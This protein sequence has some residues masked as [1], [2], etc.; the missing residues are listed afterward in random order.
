M[1]LVWSRQLINPLVKLLKKEGKMR[2]YRIISIILASALIMSMIPATLCLAA[3]MDKIDI[4]SATKEQLM[5]LT[6]VG[7]AVAVNIIKYRE[8]IG[9][10]SKVEDIIQVKGFGPKTWEKNKDRIIAN[11]LPKKNKS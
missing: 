11:P 1:T 7:E 4:N 9:G 6:G 3:E 5:T 8:E 10:F 2:K